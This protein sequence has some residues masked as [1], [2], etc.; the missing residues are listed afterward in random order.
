MQ[1]EATYTRFTSGTMKARFSQDLGCPDKITCLKTGWGRAEGNLKRSLC[2]DITFY[3]GQDGTKV[4][5][6][7][8]KSFDNLD[9]DLI[10]IFAHSEVLSED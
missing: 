9:S 8:L 1:I 2:G 4:L 3:K 5:N 10:K 6:V 7:L